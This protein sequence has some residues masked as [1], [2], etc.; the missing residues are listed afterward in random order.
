[1]LVTGL[2]PRVRGN[3]RSGG[4]HSNGRGS[5][6]A[7]AGEPGLAFRVLPVSW[8]YPRA[9]GGTTPNDKPKEPVDGLSPRVRGNPADSSGNTIY[10]G[11]IPARAG[12]PT[13]DVLQVHW[14]TVYPRACGGTAL[15]NQPHTGTAG[16]S[17]RVRGN[18]ERRRAAEDTGGSIPAR[19]G[20]PGARTARQWLYTVYPR[21]CGGT[22]S[23]RPSVGLGSG[24]SPRVRGNQRCPAI[25]RH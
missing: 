19:A 14:I 25:R 17:P 10:V 1:M 23:V 18:H 9:C 8:V 12:E 13:F 2:S 4:R 22:L 11:S 15:K 20:E 21:A 3:P 6:P 16:L 5:I 7:R 24:L